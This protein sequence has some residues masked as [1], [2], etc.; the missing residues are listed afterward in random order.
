V[1]EELTYPPGKEP[2]PAKKEEVK[3]VVLDRAV[4][5]LKAYDI[6]TQHK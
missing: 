2:S 5:L 1:Q 3:D 4:D 6:F